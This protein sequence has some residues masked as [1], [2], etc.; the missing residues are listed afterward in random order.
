MGGLGEV[1][2]ESE[3]KRILFGVILATK[4]QRQFGSKIISSW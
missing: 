2:L 1:F 4:E 3:E